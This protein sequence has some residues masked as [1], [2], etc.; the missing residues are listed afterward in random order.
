MARMAKP[1]KSAGPGVIDALRRDNAGRDP[2]LLA[3]KYA[4]M[5]RDPFI[6]LRGACHLFYAALPDVA[7]L[8]EAPQEYWYGGDETGYSDWPAMQLSSA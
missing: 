4:N 8:A 7:P 3:M 5:A 6:F 2:Q 1:S